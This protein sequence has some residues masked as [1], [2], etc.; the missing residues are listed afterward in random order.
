MSHICECEYVVCVHV[1]VWVYTSA[2]AQR[3][4]KATWV[5]FSTTLSLILETKSLPE[6]GTKLTVNEF[7]PS[8]C[9]AGITDMHIAIAG[10]LHGRWGLELVSSCLLSNSF[11][12]SPILYILTFICWLLLSVTLSIFKHQLLIY[13]CAIQRPSLC[14]SCQWFKKKKALSLHYARIKLVMI[15]WAI[16]LS[17]S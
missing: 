3:P 10:L 1:W 7:P 6:A 16:L 11:S 2:Q 5:F 14:H 9:R 8:S 4:E 17:E 12:P 15:I 13:V